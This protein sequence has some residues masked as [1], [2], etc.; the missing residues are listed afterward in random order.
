MKIE[1]KEDAI[2]IIITLDENEAKNL[3]HF[4]CRINLKVEKYEEGYDL[5]EE[6]SRKL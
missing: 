3:F 2:K 6:L 1:K 5:H 4:L